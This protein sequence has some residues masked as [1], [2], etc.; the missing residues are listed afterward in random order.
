MKE[1]IVLVKWEDA[2]SAEAWRDRDDRKEMKPCLI[3]T[4]GTLIKKS[5]D[6][7]IL[8]L[9]IDPGNG[10]VADTMRIPTGMIRKYKVIGTYET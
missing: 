6:A 9:S 10:M 4:V 2:Y 3:Y 5:E 7:V 8:T 1:K